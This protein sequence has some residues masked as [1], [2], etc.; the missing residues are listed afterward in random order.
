[1]RSSSPFIPHYSREFDRITDNDHRATGAHGENAEDLNFCRDAN[2]S[3]VV[4]LWP[5]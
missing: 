5:Q 2:F 4:G 1:M 3:G